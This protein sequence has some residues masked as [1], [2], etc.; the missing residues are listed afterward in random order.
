MNVLGWFRGLRPRTSTARR[1]L[2]T[3]HPAELA[4][5][6]EAALWEHTL[7]PWFPRCVDP[8]GGFFQAYSRRWTPEPCIEPRSVIFQARTLWVAATVAR[9]RPEKCDLYLS[10]AHHGFDYLQH[11]FWDAADGGFRFTADP[12]SEKHSYGMAFALMAVAAYYR[13]SSDPRA[14]ALGREAFAWWEH[15]AFDG[16]PGGCVEAMHPDGTPFRAGERP[17]PDA[18]GN[19]DGLRTA[20][21]QLH[22]ISSLTQFYVCD[23][24]PKVSHR[25]EE[26]LHRLEALVQSS[27]GHLY[28]AYRPD[29]QAED[30]TESFGHDLECVALT[31][32]AREVLGLKGALPVE[33]L[34]EDTLGTGRDV[35]HGGFFHQRAARG[36]IDDR[37]VWWVQVEAMHT[38]LGASQRDGPLADRC[39]E[40]FLD[41]WAFAREHQVDREL[42]GWLAETSRDGRTVMDARKGHAWKTAWH[43][44]KSLLGICDQLR[45]ER[46]RAT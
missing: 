43:E 38:L 13:A 42:T 10:W 2:K 17:H 36:S 33:P 22:L 41:T 6:I 4:S 7:D 26:S 12:S 45:N 14:L 23:P 40:S 1:R 32:E 20:N 16:Q 11:T 5:E 29:G 24:N 31:R 46:P 34:L 21:T 9:L 8:S 19:P 35:K 27:H 39:R 44:T 15:H 30:R 25:L 3:E 37:K 18:I 28:T